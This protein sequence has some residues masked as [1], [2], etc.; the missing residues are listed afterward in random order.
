MI[1]ILGVGLALSL[2]AA[3]F[4]WVS[5]DSVKNQLESLK[6]LNSKLSVE[7]DEYKAKNSNL[8]SDYNQAIQKLEKQLV[9]PE[10]QVSW[11]DKNG[12]IEN[13]I[14]LD[15]YQLKGKN[16]VVIIRMKDN[17]TQGAPNSL[18]YEKLILN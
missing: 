8:W 1:I 3:G 18:P 17:K 14:V 5:L 7:L 15:D 2:F 9:S 6:K 4:C 12:D 11:I 16:Y 13:G 10:T